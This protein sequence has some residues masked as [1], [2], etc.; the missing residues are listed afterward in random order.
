MTDEH[1]IDAARPLDGITVVEM[2][3]SVAAPFGGQILA[4]LGARANNNNNNTDKNKSLHHCDGE[5]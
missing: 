1:K 4:D 5:S 2:G 3:H